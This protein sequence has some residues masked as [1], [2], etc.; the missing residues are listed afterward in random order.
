MVVVGEAVLAAW[1]VDVLYSLFAVNGS[2]LSTWCAVDGLRFKEAGLVT[3]DCPI[4]RR[5]WIRRRDSRKST[6][7]TSGQVDLF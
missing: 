5:G 4:R 2:L 7:W 1:L 3:C 6:K